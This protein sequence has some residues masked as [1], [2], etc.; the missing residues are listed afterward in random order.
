MVQDTF[1]NGLLKDGG[2][3]KDSVST[4]T[5]REERAWEETCLCVT[6]NVFS[7]RL[8]SYNRDKG[9]CDHVG[10]DALYK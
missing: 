7:M 6:Y 2:L 1:Q 4:K 10:V 8:R 9:W 5:M 3:L